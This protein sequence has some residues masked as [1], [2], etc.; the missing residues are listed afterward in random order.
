MEENGQGPGENEM[1][2]DTI[3]AISTP[4]GTG[5]IGIIRISGRLTRR[6]VSRIFRPASGKKVEGISTHTV[7][8]GRIIDDQNR[9]VDEVLLTFMLAPRSYTREDMAEIGCHGGIV[10]MR[11]IVGLCVSHGARIALP[12]EFTRRA[13]INGRIDLLQA[14]SVLEIINSRTERSL[15]MS[16]KKLRGG[17]KHILEKT[18]RRLVKILSFIEA[19]I[20][21]PEDAGTVNFAG[22]KKDIENTVSELESFMKRA[23]RG[24][25]LYSGINSAIIGRTNAGK[26]SLLNALLGED[27]AI[28]TELAGTT[29]D[30]L[31]ETLNIRGIPVNII[32][33]AGIRKTRGRLE[34]MGIKKSLQWM[35]KAE[36]NLLVLDG[37]K[38]LNSH[39]RRLLEKVKEKLF[40]LVVNKADLPVKIEMQNLVDSFGK[41]KIVTLSA[42]TGKGIEALEERMYSLITLGYGKMENDEIFL[43]V[44]QEDK[45][46][47]TLETLR[48]VREESLGQEYMEICAEQLKECLREIDELTGRDLNEDVLETIFSKFCIGK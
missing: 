45:V 32:D 30:S 40:L 21:F 4:Q 31:Q 26:S 16:Q 27:R 7:T 34:E 18:R 41:E 12:G 11:E 2:K 38:K 46:R 35:E 47:K 44:R 5:G 42:R 1:L 36:I 39:D 48:I 10:P 3:C 33:T 15:Y 20:D 14:E 23:S 17:H 8:Y 25:V 29:R 43:N 37:S 22:I 13:F 6:I 9:I 19:G 28:V 24:R